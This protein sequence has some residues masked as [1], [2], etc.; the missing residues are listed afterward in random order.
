MSKKIYQ[1]P[2]NY[3]V[4]RD[5]SGETICKTY[6]SGPNDKASHKFCEVDDVI[7]LYM[8]RQIKKPVYSYDSKLYSNIKE[9]YNYEKLPIMPLTY[10]ENNGEK[11]T[12]L[13]AKNES[14][15]KTMTTFIDEC[16]KVKKDKFC[17]P[18]ETLVDNKNVTIKWGDRPLKVHHLYFRN[19]TKERLEHERKQEAFTKRMEKAKKEREQR[20][21][22][23][24]RTP[25]PQ[26]QRQSPPQSQRQSPQRYQPQYQQ[27]QLYYDQNG[28]QYYLNNYGQAIY[29]GMIQNQQQYYGQFGGNKTFD[30]EKILKARKYSNI[31]NSMTQKFKEYDAVIDGVNFLKGQI[32]IGDKSVFQTHIKNVVKNLDKSGKKKDRKL[33][34]ILRLRPSDYKN[35]KLNVFDN[36]I[37]LEELK[38]NIPEFNKATKLATI[39]I[40]CIHSNVNVELDESQLPRHHKQKGGKH[41][42]QKGG[43][44]IMKKKKKTIRKHKGINQKS[45]RLNKGYKYSG[46]KLKSGM[47][48]IVKSKN[49]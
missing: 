47:K 15:K 18:E 17:S 7:A 16:K 2:L 11:I 12:S 24:Q 22:P 44:K 3:F 36:D 32:G 45:G 6:K 35:K 30:L 42:K 31:D 13:Y 9:K 8:G 14:I 26:Y 38:K 41:H 21:S 27:P 40:L 10:F 28:N 49:N 33:L 34:M 43:K 4:G 48:E 25:S 46:K 19:K 29:T 23:P 39:D 5:A 20:Q 37:Q 1:I